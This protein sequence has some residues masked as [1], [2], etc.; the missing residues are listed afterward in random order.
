MGKGVLELNEENFDE[1]ISEGNCVV[2]FWAEWCGPCKMLKPIIEEVAKKEKKIKFGKI[3][4]DTQSELAQK[5]EIMGIP[6][7]IFFKNGKDI[8][9]T[10]GFMEKEELE[11][12]LEDTFD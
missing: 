4:V 11:E 9:R 6:T 8:D 1:F 3:D 5:F 7:L 2:D 12:K 10:S